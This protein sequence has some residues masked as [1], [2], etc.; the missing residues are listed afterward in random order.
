MLT[1]AVSCT[2]NSSPATVPTSVSSGAVTTAT[3]PAVTSPATTE[4]TAPPSTPLASAPTGTTDDASASSTVTARASA[5]DPVIAGKMVTEDDLP[6]ASGDGTFPTT[7]DDSDYSTPP[8][9]SDLCP[10]GR[11]TALA[12]DGSLSYDLD[13]HDAWV[14]V[15]EWVGTS[16]AADVAFQ[17]AIA[18]M[19]RCIGQWNDEDGAVTIA[20]ADVPTAPGVDEARLY[21][22]HAVASGEN[23][24]QHE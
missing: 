1:V 10:A 11:G 7:P 5:V 19:E 6:W 18:A 8:V 9:D 15:D 13:A 4:A 3:S 16:P 12:A 2:G 14:Y 17:A 20:S 24:Q 21:T 23:P 22:I